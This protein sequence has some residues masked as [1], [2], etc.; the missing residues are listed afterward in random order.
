ML[1][2]NIFSVF[3]F[4]IYVYIYKYVVC[5]SMIKKQH[6]NWKK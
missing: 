5:S 2:F 1:L 6:G 3:F 4:H